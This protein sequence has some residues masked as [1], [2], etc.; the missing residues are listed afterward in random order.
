MLCNC[1][2][3]MSQQVVKYFIEVIGMDTDN[4]NLT[5]GKSRLRTAMDY[6]LQ[7]V[8]G[9]TDAIATGKYEVRTAHML[10]CYCT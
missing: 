10:L 2:V 4:I 1:A 8:D 3:V 9:Q 6:A 5:Q 7:P